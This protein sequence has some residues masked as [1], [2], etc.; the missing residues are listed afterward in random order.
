ML[1]GIILAAGASSRMGRPKAL[2]TCR[3]GR[4]FLATLVTSFV[5]AG[6]DPVVAVIGSDAL[7]IRQAVERDHMEVRLVENPAPERGQ[8]SSLLA[9]LDALETDAPD[10]I[11]VIPV[12]QP[13]VSEETIRKLVERW[14]TTG[15]LIVR[16][17]HGNRHG[18]PVI[19]DSRVF[20]ELR[21]AD[22]RSG[23]RVVVRG[24]HADV[25][26]VDVDDE[27]AVEDI[28][29]PSDYRRLVRP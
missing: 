15:A 12:D 26:D 18:H 9:G 11:A 21:A 4:S 16:P 19:F 6:V 8:L 22:P 20:G 17:A 29:T 27:G 3:D 13:L 14:R 5:R 2:L 1:A 28:D 24:H 25:L 7:A 10:A 23:A